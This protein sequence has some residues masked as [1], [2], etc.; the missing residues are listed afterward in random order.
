MLTGA[1]A[2]AGPAFAGVAMG[3]QFNVVAATVTAVAAA[4]LAGFPGAPPSRKWWAGAL[5]VV[6]WVL[7]DGIALAGSVGAGPEA[8]LYGV[9][10]ALAGFLVGYL[11]PAVAGAAVGRAVYRG[12]GWLAAGAVAL[13]VAPAL[14][15][16]SQRIAPALWAVSR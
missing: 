8:A 12:T 7:G 4:A 16:L 14:S 2:T 9:T 1:F 15:A 5:L 3:L 13:T 6:G 11:A 10:W